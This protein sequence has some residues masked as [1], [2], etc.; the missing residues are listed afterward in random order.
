MKLFYVYILRCGDG[1]FYV[2]HTDDLEKRFNEHRTG[3][4]PC[5]TRRRLPVRLAFFHEVATRQEAF[6][7]ERRIKTW[8]HGKKAALIR[9]DRETWRELSRGCD[10]PDRVA[11]DPVKL[12]G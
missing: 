7:L 11:R 3:A 4:L 1:S 12:G 8:S 9:G 2:G 5:Y 6:E 10:R